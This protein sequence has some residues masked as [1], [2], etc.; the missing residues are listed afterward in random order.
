VGSLGSVLLPIGAALIGTAAGL[1]S[2]HWAVARGPSLDSLVMGAWVTEPTAATVEADPYALARRVR[3]G[4]TAPLG[5]ESLAFT[6]AEDTGGAALTGTCDY[7]LQGVAPPG[8]VWTLAA[9]AAGTPPSAPPGSLT[10]AE[11]VRFGQSEVQIEL[12][13]RA[14]PGNWLRVP[15]GPFR[16][17]LRL[18]DTAV[19]T[20]LGGSR[21]VFP[22]I[23][24]GR[25]R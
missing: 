23:V 14:R 8:R 12:S 22:Q 2:A 7:A 3:L 10:S 25:C 1:L 4:R 9:S 11:V 5:A 18:Y 16:L 6:A 17:T 21:S 13:P 19:A 20:T 15:D 24:R